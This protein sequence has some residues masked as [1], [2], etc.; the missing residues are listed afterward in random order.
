MYPPVSPGVRCR[1]SQACRVPFCVSKAAILVGESPA[2]VPP[3]AGGRI[4][5]VAEEES[6]RRKKS[7]VRQHDPRNAGGCPALIRRRSDPRRRR[8][9]G[10]GARGSEAPRAR[11]GG[12]W[13]GGPSGL[14]GGGSVQ[15]GKPIAAA[16]GTRIA[17]R[18]PPAG[19]T[20]PRS[21]VRGG[22]TRG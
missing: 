22:P 9:A 3:G 7:V 5:V 10:A 13:G 16:E 2:D 20:T 6:E 18:A 1:R 11:L 15:R 8:R 17:T 21:G 12:G 4:P 19:Q 14:G